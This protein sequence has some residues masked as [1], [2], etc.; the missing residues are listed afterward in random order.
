[1]LRSAKKCKGFSLAAKD[2]KIGHVRELYFDDSRWTIRYLVAQAG[3]WMTGRLV[4]I[5]PFAL[6]PI[7]HHEKVISVDLSREQIRN[8]PS[9]DA[10]LPVSRQFEAAYHTYFGWPYYWVGPY[11]WGPTPYPALPPEGSEL[12]A[13]LAHPEHKADPHLRS[14]DEVAGYHIAARDG[15]IGHVED[16]L[17]SESDWSIRY[18]CV[19][20]R[21]WLPG[22]HVLLPPSWIKEI[23]WEESRVRM[24]ASRED[25]RQAPAFDASQPVDGE[26]EKRLAE[27][28]ETELR[29]G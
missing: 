14:T 16:F 17:L 12:L 4:L 1:M 19:A 23:N 25:I 15:D 13:D 8:S 6:G 10:D 24:D 27:Y 11:L 28:Y 9:P 29:K 7:N 26:L 3:N 20:V 21:N 18:V 2:G 5:S 22:K